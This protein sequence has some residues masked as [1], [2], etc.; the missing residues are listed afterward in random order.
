MNVA[1][2]SSTPQ[3]CVS[4]FAGATAVDGARQ[5]SASMRAAGADCN[6]WQRSREE[7]LFHFWHQHGSSYDSGGFQ[8]VAAPRRVTVL[9]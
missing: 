1:V 7:F 3:R 5:P 4:D 2:G 6:E 9:L 8:C